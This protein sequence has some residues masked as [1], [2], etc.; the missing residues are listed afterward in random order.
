MK[1]NIMV[2]TK[3]QENQINLQ[4][5]AYEKQIGSETVIVWS[6]GLELIIDPY[7]ANPNIQN[8]GVQLVQYLS[9]NPHLV[10][11]KIVT[12]M[13]TGS[14]I[15]G[16]SAALLGARKINLI[17]IDPRAVKNVK[18]NIAK[19]KLQDK[20]NVFLSDLFGEFSSRE[21]SDVQIFNHPYFS[22]EPIRGKEWTRMML[23]GTKLIADYLTQ[24]PKYSTKTALYILSWL[25][26]AENES[27]IDN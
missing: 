16:I 18:K 6:N 23:G 3:E 10:K 7:V 19:H 11:G 1:L 9:D 4:I 13:G 17:D 20:C 15:I 24:A 14:G 5:E 25:P 8:S 27:G 2:L 22:V 26:L 21:L 12:D